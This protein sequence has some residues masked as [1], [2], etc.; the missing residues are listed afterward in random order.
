MELDDQELEATKKNR[1]KRCEYCSKKIN[2]KINDV[3]N[4]E[5]DEARVVFL[6]VP[7]LKVELNGEDV[8]GYKTSDFFKI[9]Y[10]P[11]CGKELK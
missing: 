10:C 2:K 6:D 9:K 1:E 4:D 8:D 11:M 3:D 5:E 7:Y